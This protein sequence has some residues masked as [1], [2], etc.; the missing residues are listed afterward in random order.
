MEAEPA[1]PAEAEEAKAEAIRRAAAH[2]PMETQEEAASFD[3]RVAGMSDAEL[4]A[5]MQEDGRGD[6]NKAH[7]PSV[8]DEYDYRHGD[9]QLQS[10]DATLVRLNESGTTLEQAEEMLANIQKDVSRLATEDRADLLGQEEAL[11]DYI[12]E[13]ENKKPVY[14]SQGNP[15]DADGNLILE[16]IS[17]VDDLRGDDFANPSRNVQLPKIPD[18]VDKAIGANGKAVII[19]KNIFEK[20][21]RDH[22]DLKPSQSREILKTALYT[23]DLYGQNQ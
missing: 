23:P 12:A 5:Y 16:E 6:L 1:K 9:E 17:S 22:R 19:K 2:F 3:K 20:N 10:Y 15:V 14:D 13:L 11:Q 8:Y 4:L 7:H 18:A 21:A